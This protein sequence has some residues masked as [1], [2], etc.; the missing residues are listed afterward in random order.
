VALIISPVA[1]LDLRAFMEAYTP[2][3]ASKALLRGFF[4]CLLAGLAYMHHMS[5][6]HK[7][8]KPAN[9]LIKGD[10]V[11][12]TDLGLAFYWEAVGHSTTEDSSPVATRKYSPPEIFTG[13]KRNTSADIFSLGCV[14]LE[15]ATLLDGSTLD[16]LQEH[17]ASYGTQSTIY[18]TN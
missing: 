9:I 10:S 1:D 7:D 14:F 11:L 2:T 8:I 4:G 15:M 17:L 6:R 16:K 3:D 5:I 13:E 18:G 12:Y